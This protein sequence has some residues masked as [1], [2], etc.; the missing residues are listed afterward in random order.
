[1]GA[2][3]SKAGVLSPAYWYAPAVFDFTA[4]RSLSTDAR[5]YF[6]AGGK[7]DDNML[8][9]LNRMTSLV[10]SQGTSPKNLSIRIDPAAQH[11][12]AAWRREFPHAV[13]WLFAL[14]R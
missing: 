8:P 7:E 2:L 4:A 1:M 5:I 14:P 12:E 3:L 11:N 13:R 9:D 6:Y 10:R